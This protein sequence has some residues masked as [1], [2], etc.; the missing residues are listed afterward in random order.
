MLPFGKLLRQL[1]H[2]RHV[3]LSQLA[4]HME[5]SVSYISDV[6]LERRQPFNSENIIKAAAFFNV[7]P[8]ILE[9]AACVSRETFPIS[10]SNRPATSI[11]LVA[12]FARGFP[13]LTEEQCGKIM[14]ILNQS[15]G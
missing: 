15:Q 11:E 7:D 13:N 2:E 12:A 4:K 8:Q 14:E 3:P 9:Q 1:R 5:M 10:T 6:E